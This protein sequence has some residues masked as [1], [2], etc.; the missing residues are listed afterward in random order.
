[1]PKGSEQQGRNERKKAKLTFKEKR[2]R[3]KE[4]KQRSQQ[5]STIPHVYEE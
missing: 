5:E 2:Q 1:M 3:K 4:K